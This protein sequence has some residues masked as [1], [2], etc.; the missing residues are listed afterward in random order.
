MILTHTPH[1]LSVV[2]DAIERE[3]ERESRRTSSSSGPI[4]LLAR[5][6]GPGSLDE[7]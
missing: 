6:L 4:T 2:S 7:T 5:M 1:M 3:R